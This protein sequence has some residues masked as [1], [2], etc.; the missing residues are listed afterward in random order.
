MAKKKSQTGD[1]QYTVLK[2]GELPE[3]HRFLGRGQ[4]KRPGTWPGLFAIPMAISFT[5]RRC[6]R[7]GAL[8]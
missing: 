4:T 2:L 3:T 8:A 7:L 1:D 6:R 5:G